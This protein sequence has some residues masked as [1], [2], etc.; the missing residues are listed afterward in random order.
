MKNLILILSLVFVCG[1]VHARTVSTLT[2]STLTDVQEAP[3][4][5]APAE[6]AP[7]AVAPEQNAPATVAPAVNTAVAPAENAPGGTLPED[8]AT[9]AEAAERIVPAVRKGMPYSEIEELYNVKDYAYFRGDERNDPTIMAICSFVLPG[10]GQ[11]IN[12][13]GK[14]GASMLLGSILTAAGGVAG[15][16]FG[17]L[18][19]SQGLIYTGLALMLG[20][21]GLHIYS[22]VDAVKVTKIMNMYHEDVGAL[23]FDIALEPYCDVV[24]FA[25]DAA[26]VAGLSLKIAF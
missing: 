11:M 4:Q 2:D 6:N 23:A 25:H 22:I 20:S 26:P 21:V 19:H 13:A 12:G 7:A 17:G 3:A 24:C 14:R 8:A 1:G 10:L 18:S 15:T 16:A 5:L 9:E